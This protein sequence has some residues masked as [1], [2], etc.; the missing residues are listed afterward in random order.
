MKTSVIL[1]TYNRSQSLARALE[2]LASSVLPEF[3]DWEILVVDNNS[4]DQTKS[5][6]KNFCEHFQGRCRYLFE[7]QQGK[8]YALNT[9]IHEAH[10]EIL[11]FL[12]DDVTVE[13]K[14]L[15][16]LTAPLHDRRY[17]GSGGPILPARGFVAPKWLALEGP[18]N[19]VG[20][21]CA[22]FNPGD[23]PGELASPPYGANMAF[24]R[25]MFERYGYFRTDLGPRPNSEMRFEDT[26]FANRLIGAGEHL[27]YVPSAIVYHE[28][29]EGRVTKKFFLA[30]WFDFGRGWVRE[31][32]KEVGGW[33]RIKI[34]ARI[35]RTG[36]QWLV[37]FD[38]QRRF[39]RKCRVWYDSG[40]L[41]EIYKLAG[42]TKSTKDEVKRQVR[43]ESSI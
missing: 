13:P 16:D 29:H 17:A 25:E 8:S 11:A 31:T 32:N 24:R 14:W 4:S 30:W 9:G 21:L 22:Y 39:Y 43:E 2:S 6:V 33:E 35:V 5:V 19:L 18:C 15:Q 23:T 36:L 26:E 40:K 12:D 41:T 28:I 20:A 42:N 10:G 38:S 34:F 3:T 1:C 37:T 27:R 7:G